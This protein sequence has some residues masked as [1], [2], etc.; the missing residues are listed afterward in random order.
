MALVNSR[1]CGHKVS[2]SAPSC[3]AC[4]AVLRI[5]NDLARPSFHIAG[6]AIVIAVATPFLS[7]TMPR[8]GKL[9]LVSLAGLVA[10][11][12]AW[13]IP[14]LAEQRRLHKERSTKTVRSRKYVPSGDDR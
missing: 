11:V 1:D 2:D 12:S 13:G 14:A 8:W 10:G 9:L 6:A 3:P 4:G 5:Y 7:S